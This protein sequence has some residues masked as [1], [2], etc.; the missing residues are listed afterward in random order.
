MIR[1]YMQQIYPN[2]NK[3][4]GTFSLHVGSF[5]KKLNGQYSTDINEAY[6]ALEYWS[7]HYIGQ[8]T[9]EIRSEEY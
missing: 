6:R 7:N 2:F 5:P 4:P 3:E 8:Y 1:Y 9:F